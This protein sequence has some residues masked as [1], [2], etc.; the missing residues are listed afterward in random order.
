MEKSYSW[1]EIANM[2]LC[3][4]CCGSRNVDEQEDI[5]LD[6]GSTEGLWADERTK[7]KE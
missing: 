3:C 5:C 1:Q 6:C 7:E 2:P 4:V